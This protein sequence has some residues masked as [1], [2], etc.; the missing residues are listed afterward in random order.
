MVLG[1][2]YATGHRL[3]DGTELWRLADLNPKKKYSAALRII[4]SPIASRDLLVVPTARGG[5]IVGVKPGATGTIT[6]DSPFEQ[7]RKTKG[8]SDV[9]SPLIHDGL[10]YICQASSFLDCWDAKTGN[11]FYHMRVHDDRYRASPVF[12]DGKIYVLSRDGTG[13]VIAAGP[14]YQVLSTNKLDD[15][16]TASPAISNGRIYLRG[17]KSLYAIGAKVGQDR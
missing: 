17:F 13:T 11:E 14:K 15:A 10:L 2:D 7:W 9:P 5:L 16:F 6:A 12:A 3:S 4:A 1:C 8:G